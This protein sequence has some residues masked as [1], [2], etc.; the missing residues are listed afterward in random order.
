MAAIVLPP[1]TRETEIEITELSWAKDMRPT[2]AGPT[3]RQDR[4]GTRHSIEFDIPVKRYAWCGAGLAS[5]LALAR[6]GEGAIIEIPEPGIPEV[7]YG[8][9]VVNGYPQIGSSISVRG[10][11]PGITIKKGKW[12][13]LISSVDGV[14][15]RYYAHFT[16][17]GDVVVP[18]NGIA[19]LQIYPMIRRSSPDGWEV[20]LS[21]PVIQGL[22]KD[23][24][25]R[26]LVRRVGVGLAF[27]IEEQE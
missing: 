11:T 24:V 4:V 2:G 25:R 22:T 21:K 3:Q 23:P 6:T 18:D 5:D 7:N 13:S 1:P 15:V 17:H 19:V 27:A 10:L 26:K 8:S 14:N 9:P 16:T 20:R 12:L